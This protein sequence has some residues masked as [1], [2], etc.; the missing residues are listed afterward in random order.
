MMLKNVQVVIRTTD[1]S[2]TR[3]HPNSTPTFRQKMTATDLLLFH[4]L[5]VGSAIDG[6]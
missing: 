3:P 1:S 2:K 5:E 4:P 6:E